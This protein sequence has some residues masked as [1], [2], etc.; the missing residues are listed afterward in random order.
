MLDTRLYFS[1]RGEASV[2]VR[3]DQVVAV[4]EIPY[5]AHVGGLAVPL[6]DPVYAGIAQV[7]VRDDPMGKPRTVRSLLQ[8]LGLRDRVR[9]SDGGLHVYGLDDVRVP[10]LGNIVLGDVVPVGELL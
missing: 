8:P 7:G 6:Q 10:G 1:S 5:A 9:A 3:L 4:R 2:V